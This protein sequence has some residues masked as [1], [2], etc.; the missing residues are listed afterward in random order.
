LKEAEPAVTRR[1][2]EDRPLPP[3]L[4]AEA[5]DPIDAFA[6]FTIGTAYVN[7]LDDVTGS[8]EAGKYADLVVIDRDVLD[9]ASGPIGDAKVVLTLVEGQAVHEDEALEAGAG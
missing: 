7:H 8:I 6:A 9:P 5:L 2:V 3:F 1:F 4:P